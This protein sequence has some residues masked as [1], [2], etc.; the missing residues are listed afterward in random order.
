MTR[1]TSSA[2]IA[3]ARGVEAFRRGLPDAVSL[4]RRAITADGHLGRGRVVHVA[5]IEDDPGVAAVT[6][7]LAR[8]LGYRSSLVVPM[9]REGQCPIAGHQ[10]P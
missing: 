7:Q 6:R 3:S 9:L 4:R 10:S 8:A 1:F 5:D 2:T